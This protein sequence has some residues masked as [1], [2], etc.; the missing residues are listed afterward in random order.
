MLVRGLPI[1]RRASRYQRANYRGALPQV[2]CEARRR[3][4]SGDATRNRPAGGEQRCRDEAEIAGIWYAAPPQVRLAGPVAPHGYLMAG[5][6][7]RC[8]ARDER[9]AREAIEA[10]LCD[11]LA[12]P[13]NLKRA[14]DIRKGA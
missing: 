7:R 11:Y 6:S 8:P 12:S 3:F 10:A 9:A 4:S 13:Y 14:A 1:C 5:N 2:C